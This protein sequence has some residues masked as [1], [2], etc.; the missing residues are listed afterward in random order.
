MNDMRHRCQ[1]V[2]SDCIL[3]SELFRFPLL[4]FA[5]S[6]FYTHFIYHIMHC[7]C[8]DLEKPDFM[9]RQITFGKM[10]SSVAATAATA[11]TTATTAAVRHIMDIGAYYNPINLFLST[12]LCPESVMIIEPI[13]DPLSVFIPC[14]PTLTN[15][16]NTPKHT[17]VLF[18]PI[19]FKYYMSIA[20][21]LPKPETV[22]C[23]GTFCLQIVVKSRIFCTYICTI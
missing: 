5:C 21:S 11:G 4:L 15:T 12:E 19:T 2:L 1:T 18:L 3:V 6:Y 17:H 9:S 20:S 23:I 7:Y 13:L 10:I 16:G 14:L 22:V 8:A